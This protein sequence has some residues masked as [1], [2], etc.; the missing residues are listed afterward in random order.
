MPHGHASDHPGGGWVIAVPTGWP[1]VNSIGKRKNTPLIVMWDE[2]GGW[3]DHVI[4]S[5]YPD[6][7]TGANEGLGPLLI[8]SPYAKVGYIS[9]QQHEI[10]SS[11][12]FIRETFDLPPLGSGTGKHFAD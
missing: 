4:P 10:A 11:T 1:I 3:Y 8:V 9:H 6:P 12:H 7:I 2:W 5:R